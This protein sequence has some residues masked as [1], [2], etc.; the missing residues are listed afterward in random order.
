MP[1]YIY[2]HPDTSE[3]FEIVHSMGEVKTPTEELLR[4]ITLED[5]RIM[6]RKIVAPALIGFDNLGRSIMNKQESPASVGCENPS[7]GKCACAAPQPTTIESK[8][9]SAV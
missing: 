1:K 5:G 4:K 3:E 8:A 2:L 9:A 7:G 6:K